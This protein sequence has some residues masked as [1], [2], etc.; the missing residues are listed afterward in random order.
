MSRRSGEI[1][2]TAYKTSKTSFAGG[3]VESRSRVSLVGKNTE[4]EV[5][6][7]AVGKVRSKLGFAKGAPGSQPTGFAKG[8]A[9]ASA[10][11]APL[12]KLLNRPP[13]FGKKI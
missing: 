7:S 6:R 4:G 10:T 12:N 8:E 3:E 13:G 11:G 2:G 1:G 9:R 5:G